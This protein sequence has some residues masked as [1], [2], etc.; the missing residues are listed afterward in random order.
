M[1]S[2]T[3][4]LYIISAALLLF[5]GLPLLLR[6]CFKERPL[7]ENAAIAKRENSNEPQN[8][9]PAAE[10]QSAKAVIPAAPPLPPTANQVDTVR[11]A[12]E[13]F[14]IVRPP[15]RLSEKRAVATKRTHIRIPPVTGTEVASPADYLEDRL[16]REAIARLIDF[17]MASRYRS[18]PSALIAEA[19][20]LLH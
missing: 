16:N 9:K 19:K 2:R 3:K 12:R 20:V 11:Q 15:L 13:S 18:T 14:A 6:A 4:A 8:T 1:T 7:E 10:P 17:S 5:G